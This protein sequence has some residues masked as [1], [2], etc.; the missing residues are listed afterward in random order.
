MDEKCVRDPRHDCFGLEAAARLEG[1]IKALEDWQ[2]DSKKFH[3]S[4][5]DWQREQIARE[6]KLDEQ[7]SNMNRNIQKLLDKQEEDDAKPGK[8]MDTLKNNAI[9]AILAAVIGFFLGNLGL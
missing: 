6:A 2:Q 7:L 4:F 9:W 5:Y 1:R 3:N 8:L